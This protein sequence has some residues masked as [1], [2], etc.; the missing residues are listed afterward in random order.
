MCRCSPVA[1]A[2]AASLYIVWELKPTSLAAG[3]ML[4]AW[5]ILPYM[6]VAQAVGFA[7]LL[8]AA[9]WLRR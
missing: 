9:S 6:A 4:G 5:L 2:A 3:A 1:A 7:V 8:V